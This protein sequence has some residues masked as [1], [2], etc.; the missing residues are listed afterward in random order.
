M[1]SRQYTTEIVRPPKLDAYGRP[2]LTE[3]EIQRIRQTK[4]RA[5]VSVET[6]LM[7]VGF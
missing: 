1:T 5:P 7:K 4:N 2:F 3:A 6:M